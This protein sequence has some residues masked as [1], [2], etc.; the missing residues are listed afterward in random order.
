MLSRIGR[1]R[2]ASHGTGGPHAGPRPG[3][4]PFFHE[5]RPDGTGV[6]LI[7]GF[8]GSPFEM[9]LLGRFLHQHGL[10]CAAPLLPG[11]GRGVADLAPTRWADWLAGAEAAL[12]DLHRRLSQHGP[13]RL[14]VI[15]L[16]MGGLL[17]LELCRRHPDL[18]RAIVLLATPIHLH[19][20]ST[21]LLRLAQPT[22]LA[23]LAVPKLVGADVRDPAM[24]RDNPAARG[25]PI[26]P[27]CSL[28]DLMDHLRPRLHEIRHPALIAHGIHDHSVPVSCLDVIA[29]GLS[30]PP[31]D[32]QRLVL[33]RS[34]HL[35]PLDVEKDVLFSAIL[36][37][38]SRYL[39]LAVA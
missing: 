9:H 7:H 38:I 27:L 19:R 14:I 2:V 6:L 12:L 33:P 11:H 18:I 34:Y 36:Q 32:L 17:T 39:T 15:G 1:R 21:R 30:T 23:R 37:H 8:T 4:A 16:S 5:G 31:A 10:T 24:R 13:P 29:G 35:L 28:L 25:M 20:V 26:L 3:A 22:R